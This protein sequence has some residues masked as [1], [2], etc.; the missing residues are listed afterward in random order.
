MFPVSPRMQIV[1]QK[2]G[3]NQDRNVQAFSHFVVFMS[4]SIDSVH[5]I[6]EIFSWVVVS[7]SA[8]FS[9]VV[10]FSCVLTFSSDEQ[11]W[12]IKQMFQQIRYRVLCGWKQFAVFFCHCLSFNICLATLAV[13]YRI[14]KLAHNHI[15]HARDRASVWGVYLGIQGPYQQHQQKNVELWNSNTFRGLYDNVWY[16]VQYS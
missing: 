14:Y 2:V 16:T 5:N 7:F 8:V 10:T 12:R 4:E 3:M 6:V 15:H 11:V 1:L 13:L 9:C